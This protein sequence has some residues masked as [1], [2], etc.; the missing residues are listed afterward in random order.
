MA[1]GSYRSGPDFKYYHVK[2]ER[3]RK[4][5][6]YLL[7]FQI[8]F[9]VFAA[10]AV[11]FCFGHRTKMTG[12][13]M[14]PT[15]SEGDTVLINRLKGSVLEIQRGDI[16]AFYLNGNRDSSLYVRRVAG[17][18]GDTIQITDG[19]LYCNGSQVELESEEEISVAGLAGE[20]ILLGADEYFV[21][22]DSPDESEDSRHANIGNVSKDEIYGTVWFTLF[23]LTHIG[24]R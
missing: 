23:P 20:E 24:L 21:I 22:G 5:G 9:V 19:I 13:A 12:D 16:V 15:I 6:R 14:S 8:V 2:D 18:P 10:Y 3:D 1:R 4:R 7:V 11:V 17:I